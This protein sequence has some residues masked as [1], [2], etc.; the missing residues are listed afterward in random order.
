M[1]LITPM[2]SW[3]SWNVWSLNDRIKCR[4]VIDFLGAFCGFLLSFGEESL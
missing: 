1:F 3:C 2:I 4:A